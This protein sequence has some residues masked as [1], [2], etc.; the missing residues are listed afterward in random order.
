MSRSSLRRWAGPAI[1]GA[2]ALVGSVL[3]VAA[4]AA[5]AASPGLVISQVYG[6]GG[7]AGAT[8]ATITR[9]RAEDDRAALAASAIVTNATRDYVATIATRK[10]SRSGGTTDELCGGCRSTNTAGSSV[11]VAA[12]AAREGGNHLTPSTT[13][14]IRAASATDDVAAILSKQAAAAS[15]ATNCAAGGRSAGPSGPSGPSVASSDGVD[16][17]PARAAATIVV[18]VAK[19][20]VAA[21]AAV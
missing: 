5:S 9:G 17:L 11:G 19:D 12:I 21:R 3:P 1:A 6:G 7:N 10:R 16:D 14:T 2:L 4:T 13:D 8:F 18:F 20:P 15:C